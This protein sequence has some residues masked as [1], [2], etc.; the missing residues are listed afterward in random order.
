VR[1]SPAAD[2]SQPSPS[3]GAR[4]S[5]R[6]PL[7]ILNVPEGKMLVGWIWRAPTN[8]ICFPKWR[9]WSPKAWSPHTRTI[10]DEKTLRSSAAGPA[11]HYCARDLDAIG[12]VYRY[13]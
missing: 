5:C 9:R 2:F 10:S 7:L 4:R 1:R 12:V 3:A 6:P 13:G 8:S 11:L